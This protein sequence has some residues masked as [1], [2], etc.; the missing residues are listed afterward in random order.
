MERTKRDRILLSDAVV[1][2]LLSAGATTET[3][4]AA[5]AAARV[6]YQARRVKERP[7]E[8]ARKRRQRAAKRPGGTGATN[9]DVPAG[10]LVQAAN[11]RLLEAAYGNVDM[12]QARDIEAINDLVRAQGCNFD[13]RDDAEF[14]VDRMRRRQQF[15]RRLAAQH[16]ATF[17]TT[18][19][20][21]SREIWYAANRSMGIDMVIAGIAI[22]VVA[23]LVVPRLMPDYSGI[24]N[25][26]F[27]TVAL[28]VVIVK[29]LWQLRR[30]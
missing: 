30:L 8:V 17:R 1:E 21:S 10:P 16:E 23:A 11:T 7:K 18:K 13:L 14:A 27:T 29:G 2:A 28:G 22:A 3:I 6:E 4:D 24:A 9:A 25:A 26:A 15:S 5:Q 20:A 12:A 19:T